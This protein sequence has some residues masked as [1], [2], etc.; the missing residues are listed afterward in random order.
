MSALITDR[1]ISSK[2]TGRRASCYLLPILTAT[3]IFKGAVVARDSNGYAVPI[4]GTDN[5]LTVYGVARHQQVNAGASGAKEITV[6]PGVYPMASTGLTYLDVG[7]KAYATSDQDF[8]T[9]SNGGARP[10]L[11]IIELVESATLAYIAIEPPAGAS[12]ALKVAVD[13]G[14]PVSKKTLTATHATITAAA[15]SEAINIGTTLPANARIVGVDM[16]SLTPFSGGTVGDFTVDIGSAGDVD[17]L[18]DGADLFA[19]AVDGGPATMPAGVRPNKTYATATQLI[20]TFR[21]GSDDVADA[22]AGSVVIDVLY[23]V[24]A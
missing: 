5:T 9:D 14:L 7:K 6:D 16:R 17:A 2:G 18:V 23:T 19:A 13:A 24:L 3:T 11:G 4:N 1:N 8:S 21:C 15:A 10:F 20:A 22:S 12:E